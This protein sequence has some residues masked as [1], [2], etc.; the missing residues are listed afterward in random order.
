MLADGEY[1]HGEQCYSRNHFSQYLVTSSYA[2]KPKHDGNKFESFA[3]RTELRWDAPEALEK[4][5]PQ[6][7]YT[8]RQKSGDDWIPY[9]PG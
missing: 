6:W 3:T 5:E 4:M 9:A 7:I 8:G 2:A 1:D